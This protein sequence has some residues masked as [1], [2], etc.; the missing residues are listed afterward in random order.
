MGKLN[1]SYSLSPRGDR[2][3]AGSLGGFA[4]NPPEDQLECQHRSCGHS[5]NAA[6]QATDVIEQ[7]GIRLLWSDEFTPKKRKKRLF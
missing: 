2:Y 7:R 3:E 6:F 1:G 5:N 4:L